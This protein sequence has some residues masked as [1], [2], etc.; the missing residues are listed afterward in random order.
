MGISEVDAEI[1]AARFAA[2]RGGTPKA[3]ACLPAPDVAEALIEAE[4]TKILEEDGWRALR[5]DPVSDRGRGKGFGELGMADHFYCRYVGSTPEVMARDLRSI[6]DGAQ[7]GVIDC[8]AEII[9]IEFKR[10]G[11][12]AKKHQTAWHTRE[13]ARGALTLIAG[14]D[15]PASVEGFRKWYASSGLA[16][17]I[18]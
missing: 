12:K 11:E 4:C 8:L 15:F 16:R 18:T 6:R 7:L 13:R 1:L 5:T 3:V 10:P 9:W 14:E 17:R 2:N